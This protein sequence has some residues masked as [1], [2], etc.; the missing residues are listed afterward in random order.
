MRGTAS[1]H[2][3]RQFGWVAAILRLK[4]RTVNAHVQGLLLMEERS[5]ADEVA[6]TRQPTCF[7]DSEVKVW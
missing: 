1:T 3:L 7:F 6:G 5:G 4:L 2:S